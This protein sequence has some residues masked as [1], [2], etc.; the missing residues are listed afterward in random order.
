MKT[1]SSLIRLSAV[2]GLALAPIAA[3]DFTN[4]DSFEEGFYGKS[5]VFDGIKV[6]DVNN[7]DGVNPDGQPFTPDEV[8]TE[9]IIENST[10]LLNDYPEAGSLPNMLTFGKAYVNGPNLSLGALATASFT[11][12]ASANSASFTLTYYDEA[13]WDGIEVILDATLGGKVV[14]T[15]SFKIVGKDPGDKEIIDVKDLSVD[16]VTFDTLRIHASLNGN[17]TTFRAM[18]D[19][20]TIVPAPGD[21]YADFDASGTLDLFDFLSFVNAFNAGQDAADCDGNNALDL[22]DFLCFVNAFNAGC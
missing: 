11:T 5:F 12:G 16:G 3:A 10:Y 19:N 22:F 1:P 21:C 6:F 9:V 20:L 2:V 14:S 15:Q 7:V 18:I 8:G 4:F 13:V 17:N